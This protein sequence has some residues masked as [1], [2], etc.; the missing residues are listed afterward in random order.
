MLTYR[1]LII[2]LLYNCRAGAADLDLEKPIF[3][4]G[5]AS[6][7]SKADSLIRGYCGNSS[8]DWTSV[9]I[10]SPIFCNSTL[11]KRRS[12]HHRL[13]ISGRPA[14]LGEFPSFARLTFAS[15][16]DFSK[17]KI[18]GGTI[19]DKDRIL[20]AA[21][22]VDDAY[23]SVQV[24]TGIV[25]LDGDLKH[26]QVRYGQA[27]CILDGYT[28]ESG[29]P[30]EPRPRLSNDVAIIQV[31][32][33]FRYDEWT[34]P[35]CLELDREVP[36]R[37]ICYSVATGRASDGSVARQVL[38]TQMRR[39]CV[40]GRALSESNGRHC[41]QSNDG[42][43]EGYHCERDLGSPMLCIDACDGGKARHYVVG[44]FSY[45]PE[46]GCIKNK[47]NY[48]FYS[49]IHKLREPFQQLLDRCHEPGPNTTQAGRCT[50]T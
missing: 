40:I 34:Q 24:Q 32:K 19:I 16:T 30:E 22:C 33:P 48:T 11:K 49:D 50:I 43:S 4:L 23:K 42:E 2:C 8:Y 38:T 14:R 6:P 21:Y 36:S 27:I 25:D 18:C 20:T 26:Q 28:I 3:Q 46:P 44:A 45:S 5:K 10:D 41:W 37:A 35:A 17:E 15:T 39:D 29:T 47:T 7:L 1:W 9:V 31:N 12:S 13:L